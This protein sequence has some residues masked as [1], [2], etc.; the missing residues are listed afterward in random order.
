M[1]E[2]ETWFIRGRSS[3][4]ERSPWQKDKF[5]ESVI[6]GPESSELSTKGHIIS[7][8]VFNLE[9]HTFPRIETEKKHFIRASTVKF[10]FES[11]MQGV[12]M[13]MKSHTIPLPRV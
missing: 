8:S 1:S 10:H 3:L 6:V 11:S 4:M 12:Y 5:T 7:A 9:L 13:N 2:L